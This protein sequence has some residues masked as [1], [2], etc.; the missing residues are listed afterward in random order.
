MISLKGKDNFQRVVR[1]GISKRGAYAVMTILKNNI[2]EVKVGIVVSKKVSNKAVERNKI[3][4]RT[5]A[6]I[7]DWLKKEGGM[8]FEMVVRANRA[9]LEA[10]FQNLKEDLEKLLAR[11]GAKD[12]KK[13]STCPH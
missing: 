4:R 10:G 11:L 7:T 5:R 9:A 2:D 12:D 8:G 1:V 6:I 3:R 13:D